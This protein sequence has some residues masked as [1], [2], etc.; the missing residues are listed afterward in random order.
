MMQKRLWR[1][2]LLFGILSWG[3]CVSAPGPKPEDPSRST[4]IVIQNQ[5]LLDTLHDNLTELKRLYE[6]MQ[7]ISEGQLFYGSDEQLCIVQKSSLR[8]LS[9]QRLARHQEE[10]LSFSSGIASDTRKRYI[11]LLINGLERSVFETASDLNSLNTYYAFSENETAR[12]H[13]DHA[14]VLIREN[15]NIY[16]NLIKEL[17]SLRSSR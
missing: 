16:K 6:E 11:E 13:I 10:L 12:E 8:I 1:F 9:S 5:S 4:S 14:V 3:G 15:M 17:N 2:L 7:P